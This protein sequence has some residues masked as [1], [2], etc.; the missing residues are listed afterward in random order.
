MTAVACPAGRGRTAGTRGVRLAGAVFWLTLLPA[1]CRDEAAS[2]PNRV[3][4]LWF[5]NETETRAVSSLLREFERDNP[6][7]HVDLTVIEWNK[8]VEKTITMMLGGHAPDLARMSV[9]HVPRF[10]ELDALADVGPEIARWDMDDWDPARLASCRVGGKWV[11]LPQS[12]I[13]LVVYYNRDAFRRIG[14]SPP[15]TPLD[16]W[17]L[18]EFA[19][20]ARRLQTDGGMEYGW[21]T[22]RGFFP[23]MAFV[24]MHGGRLFADDLE[25]PRFSSPEVLAALRWFVD[26]HRRGI[27][28]P[29][30]WSA[31]GDN[32]DRLFVLGRCGMVVQGSWMIANYERRI[33]DFEWGVTYLPRGLHAGTN[34]GGENLVV[35]RTP[36]R[37]AALR[38]LGHLTSPGAIRRFCQEARFIP[39]RAS[40]LR[41]GLDYGRYNEWM[42]VAVEQSRFFRPQWGRE[43]S[44]PAFAVVADQLCVRTE[45]A[46]LGLCP[47]ERAMGDLTEDY[48]GL[49]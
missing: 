49:R 22:F 13:V 7:L 31:G 18:E 43:Q 30:S 27:A 21:G 37:A 26:Q 25:T 23:L 38:L 33:R 39:P 15:A 11:G 6:G 42:R 36:R 29:A 28:P 2:D 45:M 47:P 44:A 41:D 24:Y 1:G 4:F 48:R 20:V 14:V 12:S 19:E 17:T 32:A 3:K 9:Q 16:A 34:V 8:Y 40:L 46:V 35:F 10:V 5:G